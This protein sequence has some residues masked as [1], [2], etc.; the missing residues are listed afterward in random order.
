MLSSET[1]EQRVE[2]SSSSS[3]SE[4]ERGGLAEIEEV[5]SALEESEKCHPFESSPEPGRTRMMETSKRK[6]GKGMIEYNRS[7][8]RRLSKMG[9][10]EEIGENFLPKVNVT[11]FHKTDTMANQ[12][13]DPKDSFEN[14]PG[15]RNRLSVQNMKFDRH[16]A[17]E[18]SEARPQHI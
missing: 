13:A 15:A 9:T 17:P 3:S 5:D 2:T 8:V 1:T 4:E 10:S 18:M 14:S 16:S 11:Q 7:P 12:D 6:K